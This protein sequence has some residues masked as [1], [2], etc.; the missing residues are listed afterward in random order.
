[1]DGL[2]AG[3]IIIQDDDLLPGLAQARPNLGKGVIG[4]FCGQ[5]GQR[6]D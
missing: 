3:G 5:R 2:C 1:M 4:P 6:F